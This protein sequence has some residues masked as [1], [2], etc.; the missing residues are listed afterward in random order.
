MQ[1]NLV[2]LIVLI[3]N[4]EPY[5]VVLIRVITLNKKLSKEF[6]KEKEKWWLLSHKHCSPQ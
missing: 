5:S 2:N 1:V 4:R 3:L 6:I